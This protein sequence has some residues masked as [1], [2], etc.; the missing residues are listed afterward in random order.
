[1]K[2]L[3]SAILFLAFFTVFSIDA[4]A[5]ACCATE[6]QYDII[7]QAPG[8]QQ[9]FLLNEIKFG[10]ATDLYLGEADFS[11]T[12]G[13]EMLEKDYNSGGANF[14]SIE[15][16]FAA[17]NFKFNFKTTSGK[18]GTL[19][20][21]LP[22]QMVRFH[23]D[24]HDSKQEGMVT[25]YKEWRFKGTVASGNG[26]FKASI[27]KPTTY[28]LVFQGRGNN[29]DDA[30]DFDRWRLEISGKNAAYTF[31]GKMNKE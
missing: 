11:E 25:L 23:A 17:K 29:C 15:N 5:C 6:N 27:L 20:L 12:K 9:L 28:F 24:L 3:T 26:F 14:F 21:P 13:L 8:E 7:T 31:I 16:L 4:F 2:K 18:T 19:M 1:M 22:A 10:G 30:T